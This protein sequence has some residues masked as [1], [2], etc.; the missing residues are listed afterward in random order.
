M[1]AQKV[2]Y[3]LRRECWFCALIG[4]IISRWKR[5]FLI[6]FGGF[7]AT[8]LHILAR[9][10]LTVPYF[11]LTCAVSNESCLKTQDI[12]S[13]GIKSVV[14]D[15]FLA[16]QPYYPLTLELGG[17]KCNILHRLL[18]TVAI[19]VEVMFK[20]YLCMHNT[21]VEMWRNLGREREGHYLSALWYMPYKYVY[22]NMR[23][24]APKTR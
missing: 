14:V 9:T 16:A 7:N 13:R 10:S 11:V 19:A 17:N 3:K 1:V 20:P 21:T 15:D 24:T 6:H 18:Y 22:L 8:L 23:Y 4:D 5:Q 2:S 12:S